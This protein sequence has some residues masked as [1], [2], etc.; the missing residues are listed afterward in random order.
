VPRQIAVLLAVTAAGASGQALENWQSVDVSLLRAGVAE[1]GLHT[2]IRTGSG[3]HPWTYARLGPVVTVQHRPWLRWTAGFWQHESRRDTEGWEGSRRVYGGAE[4]RWYG[5]G[6]ALWTRH[7][8]ERFWYGEGRRGARHRHRHRVQAIGSGRWQPRVSHEWVLDAGGVQLI[9]PSAGF[10][11]FSTAHA[12]LT[13][14]YQYDFRRESLG[15]NRH[16]LVTALRIRPGGE[17]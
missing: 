7:I 2:Q 12:D 16:A 11:V 9:R 13:V 1:I 14:T 4:I 8:G 15:G 3:F 5:R 17:R 10:R 6:V